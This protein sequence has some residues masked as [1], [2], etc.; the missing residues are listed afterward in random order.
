MDG[1][2]VVNHLYLLGTVV[3]EHNISKGSRMAVVDLA[4]ESRQCRT[5]EQLEATNIPLQ[6]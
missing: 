3:A 6:G 5:L 1:F 2:D 4:R